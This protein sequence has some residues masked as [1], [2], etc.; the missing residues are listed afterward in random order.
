MRKAN[1]KSIIQYNKQGTYLN[2]FDTIID[3]SNYLNINY[4]NLSKHLRGFSKTI[5]G[6]VFKYEL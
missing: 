4:N 1:G 3:A 5:G 2:K 6:Y